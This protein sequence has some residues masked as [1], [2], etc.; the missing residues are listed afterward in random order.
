MCVRG[1][2]HAYSTVQYGCSAPARPRATDANM[3]AARAEGVSER[4]TGVGNIIPENIMNFD[5]DLKSTQKR[6]KPL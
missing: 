5:F 3:W 2:V 6:P 1:G 4:G